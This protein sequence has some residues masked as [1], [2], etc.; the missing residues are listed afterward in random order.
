MSEFTEELFQSFVESLGDE[1]FAALSQNEQCALFLH[2]CCVSRGWLP[3]RRNSATETPFRLSLGA[4]R[5][6][7]QFNLLPSNWLLSRPDKFRFLYKGEPGWVELTVLAERE[8]FS[9]HWT[10]LDATL[11]DIL[12]VDASAVSTAGGRKMLGNLIKRNIL[13]RIVK[14]EPP[15][16][17]GV[18][19]RTRHSDFEYPFSSVSTNPFSRRGGELVGPND[20]MFTGGRQRE[21]QPFDP[22]FDPIGPGYIGEPNHD[23]F[24]PPPFGVPAGRRPAGRPPLRGPDLM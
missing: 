12:D 9:I 10:A 4:P 11:T 19:A 6:P 23:H 15:E 7:G 3:W 17:T 8:P 13:D 22:R 2:A 16:T 21:P 20:P 1:S 5:S 18:P 24:A 14:T